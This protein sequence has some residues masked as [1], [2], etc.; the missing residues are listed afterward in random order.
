MTQESAHVIPRFNST[1]RRVAA[2][3]SRERL[4]L[5]QS[6]KL[7]FDG[8]VFDAAKAQQHAFLAHSFGSPLVWMR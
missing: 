6:L 7:C 5:G 2:I 8:R 3:L 1:I 4:L